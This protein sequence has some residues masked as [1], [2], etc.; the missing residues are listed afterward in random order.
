MDGVHFKGRFY[1]AIRKNAGSPAKTIHILFVFLT[2]QFNG[3]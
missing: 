2:V 3:F 1:Y